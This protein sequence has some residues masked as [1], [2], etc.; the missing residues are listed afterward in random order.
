[1][2]DTQTFLLGL[3]L[4]TGLYAAWNIGAND[5]ANAMGTSVGSGALTLR[6][7]VILAAIFEFLGAVIVGSNVSETVRKKMFDPADLTKIYGKEEAALVLGCGMIA[8]LLAAGTW[9]LI[10]TWKQWP[11]STTHSI[12]GAVVGFG[13]VSLGV[14]LI[15]WSKVGL[16]T[17]G[18]VV[19]PIMSGAIAYAMFTVILRT[20][21]YKRDP[22]RAAREMA[23]LLVFWVLVVLCG[24]T[25]YKGL[26][27]L[28]SRFDIDPFAPH[29]VATTIA[30]AVVLG[31]IGAFV[32]KWLLR[33]VK[34]GPGNTSNPLLHADVARSLG[35]AI[36]HL[37]RV[38]ANT[39]DSMNQDA[40][41][42]LDQ[43][44]SMHTV[45]IK[46]TEKGTDSHELRKVEN[47]F[48]Y[49]QVLTACFVA[50]AHGANDVANAIGPLSAGWQA[51]HDG[52]I[53]N[54]S[55]VPPWALVIGGV[56]IV[57]GLATWGWRVIKTVGERITELTPSRGFCAE[58]AAAV[59]IL[60]ASV[61]PFGL[62]VSTTHTL[63]GAVLGVGFA[64]GLAALNL[65]TMRDIVASWAITIPAGAL[66]SVFFF[67]VLKIIVL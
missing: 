65:R 33:D 41:Q 67:Y 27:P 60:L 39:D 38:R 11:V 51:V 19:S 45:A 43:L 66:L 24:V 23:P 53:N 58:F 26:K 47:I 22:V 52:V 49:L 31:L 55:A 12:V 34:A 25:A 35:K 4:F 64:R 44:E 1:M 48:V 5:V 7:A 59:T 3:L 15:Q 8:S 42:L 54:E 36:M 46:R 10:A 56:G 13:C 40:V 37:K 16:I 30:V 9:L 2:I 21:F 29:A 17:V 28:Y 50:F 61:L 20:V 32:T 57:L 63:V 18:W 6:R 62:P 14:D